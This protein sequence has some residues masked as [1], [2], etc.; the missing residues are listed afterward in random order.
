MA[1]Q[2]GNQVSVNTED[3][4]FQKILPGRHRLFLAEHDQPA[5]DDDTLVEYR[6]KSNKVVAVCAD[7]VS[8]VSF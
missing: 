1:F 2:L 3:A 7:A 5:D 4:S 8:E 6:V